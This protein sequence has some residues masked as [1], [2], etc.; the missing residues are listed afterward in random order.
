[1]CLAD[2]YFS[3]CCVV[4]LGYALQNGKTVKK[5]RVQRD[6][7]IRSPLV[8]YIPIVGEIYN[9]DTI[10]F[11]LGNTQALIVQF[12]LWLFALFLPS[13]LPPKHAW[14]A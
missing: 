12:F 9:S 13:M 6:Y 7:F 3:N 11:V 10:R 8:Q 2:K 4:G 5:I 1:M 14:S